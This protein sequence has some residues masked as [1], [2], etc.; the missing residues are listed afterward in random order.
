MQV[1]NHLSYSWQSQAQRRQK[2][3]IIAA[4]NICPQQCSVGTMKYGAVECWQ[5]LLTYCGHTAI[6]YFTPVQSVVDSQNNKSAPIIDCYVHVYETRKDFWRNLLTSCQRQK[7][8]QHGLTPVR[9]FSVAWV[10]N[11]QSSGPPQ[12]WVSRKEFYLILILVS[13]VHI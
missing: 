12:P 4:S 2:Q 13:N 11:R 8:N 9:Y 3:G 1:C 10:S 7:V 6:L 5:T